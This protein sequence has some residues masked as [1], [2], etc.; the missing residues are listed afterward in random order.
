[1][2]SGTVQTHFCRKKTVVYLHQ[3]EDQQ[4]KGKQHTRKTFLTILGNLGL[5]LTL[6][7]KCSATDTSTFC[8]IKDIKCHAYV[9]GT[10]YREVQTVKKGC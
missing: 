7:C 5:H 6:R 2:F 8:V 4:V 3:T 9:S 1:M 10:R